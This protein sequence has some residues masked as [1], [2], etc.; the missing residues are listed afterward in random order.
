MFLLKETK[1]AFD[2]G[3]NSQ[4]TDDSS[5][6]LPTVL[7]QPFASTNSLFISDIFKR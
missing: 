6:A 4:L 3:S 2:W 7:C 1:G 5:D